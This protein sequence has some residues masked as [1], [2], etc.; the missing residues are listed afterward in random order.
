[1]SGTNVQLMHNNEGKIDAND[2][3]NYVMAHPR[4]ES[5]GNPQE[6]AALYIV[7]H[8][9]QFY[10]IPSSI[11]YAINKK[12]TVR[13]PKVNI[14]GPPANQWGVVAATGGPQ[15]TENGIPVAID[16]RWYNDAPAIAAEHPKA[17]IYDTVTNMWILPTEDPSKP[18]PGPLDD[19]NAFFE[20]I[21]TVGL[22]V[23]GLLLLSTVKSIVS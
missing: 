15:G 9:E 20:K 13:S 16:P 2:F 3:I 1:M 23:G 10:N 18:P 5:A 8:P 11:Q 17:N 7:D 21:G 12:Q 19:V 4:P 6:Y 22:I 14:P